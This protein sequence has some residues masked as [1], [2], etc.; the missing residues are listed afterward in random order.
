MSKKYCSSQSYFDF[1]FTPPPTPKTECNGIAV[2]NK[3]GPFVKNWLASQWIQALERISSS[4]RQNRAKSYVR[5]RHVLYF[6]IY[7]GEIKALVQ[8]NKPNPYTIHVRVKQWT[9]EEWNTFFTTFPLHFLRIAECVSGIISPQLVDH[10]LSNGLSLIPD[11]LTDITLGCNCQDSELLCK[12]VLSVLYMVG[13]A[14]DTDPFAILILRGKYHY[15]VIEKLLQRFTE[16]VQNAIDP[17]PQQELPN[18]H[19]LHNTKSFWE[20]KRSL[21]DPSFSIKDSPYYQGILQFGDYPLWQGKLQLDQL[22]TLFYQP[23]TS[24]ASQELEA[25][26]NQITLY[27]QEK[28]FA[29]F[30]D[31][32]EAESS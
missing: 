14:F 22:W 15:E 23:L 26:Q 19:S 1:F 10:Y 18:T 27:Q 9:E 25:L 31:E 13:I 17:E 28:D 30:F 24:T 6:H 4:S 16:S 21:K 5:G 11:F 7:P 20:G 8:G 3:K 32:L 29:A 12:H 2:D